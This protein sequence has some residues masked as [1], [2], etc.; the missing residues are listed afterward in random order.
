MARKDAIPGSVRLARLLILTAA[1]LGFGALAAASA[2]EVLV[3]GMGGNIGWRVARPDGTVWF[4]DCK[5]GLIRLGDGKAEAT[6]VVCDGREPARASGR[7]I[8]FDLASGVLR[9]RDA[10]GLEQLFFVPT[11]SR[12]ALAGLAE[13]QTI[14]VSGPVPG[15]ADAVRAD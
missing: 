15:H 9:L 10:Q 8:G 12:A 14:S 1:A 2:E 5:G 11:A 3:R 4:R 6:N 7:M 13:G